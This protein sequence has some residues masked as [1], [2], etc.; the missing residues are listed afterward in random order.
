MGLGIVHIGLGGLSLFFSVLAVFFEPSV[1]SWASGIWTSP[2][3]ILCGICGILA[4]TRWYVDYQI[5]I[6]LAASIISTAASIVCLYLTVA[7]IH[8]PL[9]S[10]SDMGLLHDSSSSNEFF[11]SVAFV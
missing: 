3:H 7:G 9:T 6:F 10:F 4:G 5:I 1:N 11:P 2:F 8:H